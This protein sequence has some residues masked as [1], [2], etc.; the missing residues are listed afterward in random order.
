VSR[1]VIQR[2]FIPHANGTV[3]WG[4]V[5][6]GRVAT[7]DNKKEREKERKRRGL[8]GWGCE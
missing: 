4:F 8:S 7:P 6:Y 1:N 3:A 5:G 2:R